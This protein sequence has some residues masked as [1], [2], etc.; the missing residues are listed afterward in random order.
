MPNSKSKLTTT[1]KQIGD[2]QI[3]DWD[4]MSLLNK[5]I[6]ELHVTDSL[7]KLGKLQVME[8]DF[9]NVLPA[10]S[11]LANQEVDIIGL[12]KR[13]AHYKVMEWDFRSALS[14]G[15]TPPPEPAQQEMNPLIGRLKNFL[16]FVTVKLIDEP[17]HA[18][19]KVR[20]IAPGV[21]R[22]KLVLVQRDVAMLIGREGH[23]AAAIRGLLKAAAGASGVQALLQIH[24]HEEEV[25]LALREEKP[26]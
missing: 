3:N 6:G 10:V 17:K 5:D 16:E 8:W 21:L 11:Q 9:R 15:C 12:V 26:G 13:T 24:S 20:E 7:R 18:Q 1:L 22:F 25:A 2:I 14:T 4:F 23:T 19:I